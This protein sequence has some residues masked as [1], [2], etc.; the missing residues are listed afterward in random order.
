MGKLAFL[1]VPL[2]LCAWDRQ[3]AVEYLETRQQQWAEWK[4]A[5]KAGGACVSCHTG[6]SYL[7]SRRVLA[8]GEP[9]PVERDL[10]QGVR[11]RLLNHPPKAMLQDEGAE[12]I[13][14]LLALSLQRRDR[15]A[16]PDEAE[17]VA[18]K[19]LWD[20]QIREGEAR[21][22]WTWFM[23]ELHPVE[24]E[25]SAFYAATLAELA[26]SAYPKAEAERVALMRDYVARELPKQPLHNRLAWAAFTHAKKDAVLRDLWAAQSEDGGW[27]NA[28]LG[29]WA[30]HED[31]PADSGS[32]GYATA[33]AA[34]AA[35]Q[36]G[37][38]CTEPGMK[39]ALDWL[40]QKQDRATGAWNA[41]SMNKPYP[42]GSMQSKF[43]TD[44]A[45]GFAAAAL[46]SC[47][48]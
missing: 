3:K 26:L 14:N 35:R 11:T 19:R 42:A 18:L 34:Y 29:P 8:E 27:T 16:P 15:K 40:T 7:L 37:A 9:R 31:A 47:G 5:K 2:A 1:F 39:R 45:T 4:P 24:S 20:A 21:G 17:R 10:V 46:L 44:M 41:V 32:N 38:S 6:L 13:L 36:A 25:H 28:A 22:G 48:N 33:W 12:A 43:M 23:H 30:K